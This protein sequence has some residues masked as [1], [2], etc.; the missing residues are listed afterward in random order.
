MTIRWKAAEQYFTVV[1]FN[2]TQV[3]ILENLP[4][5]DLAQ[6]GVKGLTV[7]K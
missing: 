3:L 6:S 5:L 2:F 7:F 1:M 4:F